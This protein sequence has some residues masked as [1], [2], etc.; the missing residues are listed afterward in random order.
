M[1]D[2]PQLLRQI[3]V[4]RAMG[5]G[6]FHIHARTG[7][8]TEY[9][10]DEFM[11]AVVACTERA[12]KLS[13]L[14]WLYDEDRWPSGFAGGIVTREEQFRAKRLVWT[15]T[16]RADAKPLASF[17]VRL[18]N[19]RLDHYRRLKSGARSRG[20]LGAIWHAY[21]ESPPADA[22]FNGQTDVDR[23]NRAAI[24]R[25]IE[26]THERYE[27]AV[28]KYFGGVVPAIFTDEPQM[29]K[30]Q[31]MARAAD[32]RD[33]ILPFTTDFPETF[34]AT[35]DQDLL[36][37][38]PELFWNLRDNAP[39]LARWRY[40]DH[41]AERFA[42]AFGDTIAR[43]CDAHGIALC[44]H[45]LGEVNLFGQ[46]RGVGEVMR[47]MRSFHL[48]G[49][50]I[51]QDKMELTTA[52]QAQSLARQFGRAGVV[53]E[54]Y[55]VTNWDFDFIGHKAQGD[56]QAAL[57]VTVRVPHLAWVSMAGEAKR[58]YPAS[59]SSQSPWWREYPLI[60]NHFA[61]IN[62]VMTRGQAVVRVGV[63]HPIESFWLNW[64]S[65]D[66]NQPLLE[67]REETF[68]NVTSW[69][70]FGLIDFD[71]IS[72][73][74]LPRQS[75]LKY[76]AI[77]V[78]GL[79]TMRATTLKWLT[80]RA[81]DGATVIFAGEVPSL[82]DV[83]PSKAVERFAKRCVNVP[84]AKRPILEA[85]EAV[86]DICIEHADATPADSMLYQLRADGKRR[87]LFLCN[88]D[89]ERGRWN[90]SIRIRRRWDVTQLDTMSGELR[91]MH[92]RIDDGETIIPW[93]FQSHDHLLL[94]LEPGGRRK[95][96][97]KTPTKWDEVTRLPGQ[98]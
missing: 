57:G 93:T 22:W 42:E 52:K 90:T 21:L 29:P 3:D 75:Q 88:T 5:F 59:I 54:L 43:W 19:G 81:K 83:K 70:A 84:M 27:T 33:V 7:L 76:D 96:S 94:T 39:S 60:E 41:T 30:K 14:A 50:D 64:G 97:I 65:M 77:I 80:A 46:T 11:A 9:L 63:I 17:D 61:R 62:T 86:R 38:L 67:E 71:Y 68:K 92:A 87:H 40:H 58:D 53:S 20:S 24:E 4:F 51:L 98:W 72:E 16:A 95:V 18:K 44:G 32:E 25:F 37:H 69:L 13:M 48:P 78:P 31:M 6:G 74:L 91:P 1:V 26:I 73:T 8:E 66:A 82:V 10:G 85:L 12:A 34:R 89:R 45:M 36:D 49:I 23:F 79:R 15:R 55:G 56:W 28:G 35:Y 47:A 2:V